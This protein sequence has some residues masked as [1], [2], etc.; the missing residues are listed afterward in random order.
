MTAPHEICYTPR[1]SA[2]RTVRLIIGVAGGTGSGKTTVAQNLALAL[3]K[4]ESLIVEHDW[5]YRDRSRLSDDERRQVNYDH[6]DA[7][8]T[9]LL[10]EHLKRL[11]AGEVVDAPR[12]DFKTHTRSAECRAIRP[13]RAVI[14]EGI[15]VLAEPELRAQFDIKIF[16]DTDADLRVLRRI[17]RDLGERGRSF[18]SVHEQ[19]IATVRPMFLEFVEPSKRYADLIIPEGG[20]NTVAM[21]VLVA[22]LRESI[23][24]PIQP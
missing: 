21:D 6:P 15:L 12:Y 23:A 2:D 7:L 11:R 17:R 16:V 14:V 10:V 5:Y 19:Y 20:E 8:E 1:M 3:P 18:Q 13:T 9:P 4:D 22:R 24:D